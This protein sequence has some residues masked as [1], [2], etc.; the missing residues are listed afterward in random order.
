MKEE[1]GEFGNRGQPVHCRA[2]LLRPQTVRT[3]PSMSPQQYNKEEQVCERLNGA[4]YERSTH[5]PR[6]AV[7][8]VEVVELTV[9][10]NK[11]E[12]PH[13]GALPTQINRPYNKLRTGAEEARRVLR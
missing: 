10:S 1:V 9:V 5:P 7:I 6:H 12:E 8:V 2:E 13:H 3:R 11:R 4:S